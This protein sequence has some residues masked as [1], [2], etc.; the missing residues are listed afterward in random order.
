MAD[1]PAPN[2]FA[3]DDL[4]IPL[5]VVD[6]GGHI[7]ARN[8]VFTRLAASHA[9]ATVWLDQIVTTPVGERPLAARLAECA[10]T[11]RS[12]MTDVELVGALSPA[13]LII[14]PNPANDSLL[15]QIV[16]TRS[17][18]YRSV[19]SDKAGDT[20]EQ[21][22]LD[23]LSG[24]NHHLRTPVSGVLGIADLLSETELDEQ[25]RTYVDILSR[26][27]N[28][29][30]HLVDEIQ[31]ITLLEQG[32][33]QVNA[34]DTDVGA[35]IES[36]LEP[37][38]LAAEQKQLATRVELDEALPSSVLLDSGL[39]EQVLSILLD[40]AVRY[41]DQGT[42]KVSVSLDKQQDGST[43]QLQVADNGIGI[44]KERLPS[45]FSGK[46]E[47][48]G[49]A[50]PRYGS[51]GLGLILCHKLVSLLGGTIE[52]E[53]QFGRGT[54]FTVQLPIGEG[55]QSPDMPAVASPQ[56]QQTPKKP[57]ALKARERSPRW[58]I[59][60]AEDNPVNQMLFRSI[61]ERLGHEITVVD[62]GQEAV[63]K[64][65]MGSRFDIILMDI[66]MP[67]MDG[68]QATAMIRSLFGDVGKTPILALTAH[69]LEGDREKF[70]NA[71]M[72]GYQAKPVDPLTLEKAIADVIGNRME[73]AIVQKAESK[74]EAKAPAQSA[75]P[76][77]VLENLR[78]FRE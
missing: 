30:M 64:V 45:L 4:P 29:L 12:C 48:D 5:A 2:D 60:V 24:L 26:S 34:N 16:E 76:E 33:M 62:N 74:P 49:T 72:D 39:L 14:T 28:A 66:S 37:L 32:E 22:T 10:R 58:R 77:S 38:R 11:G 47:S 54:T 9:A 25:Q 69:T 7:L 17:P 71:G 3:F 18:A 44:A 57:D 43:L 41:T 1:G 46:I 73:S 31:A 78:R 63:A 53:S 50:P 67:V 6:E 19:A 70:I 51:A 8:R 61:L 36:C 35:L 40:N 52:V 13:S 15:A 55:E 56:S 21:G 65:Q 23:L 42:V 68:L 59:L 27:C 75:H 20:R